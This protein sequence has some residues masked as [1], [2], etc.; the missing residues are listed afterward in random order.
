MPLDY[1]GCPSL[2]FEDLAKKYSVAR[3]TIRISYVGIWKY[4]K[5]DPIIQDLINELVL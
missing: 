1:D 5:Q 4:L 2:S 3:E